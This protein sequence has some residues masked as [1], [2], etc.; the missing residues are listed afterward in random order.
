MSRSTTA[1]APRDATPILLAEEFAQINVRNLVP[2]MPKTLYETDAAGKKKPK[3]WVFMDLK[4][5]HESGEVTP[6]QVYLPRGTGFVNAT[7]KYAGGEP[8][9]ME[10]SSIKL[11]VVENPAQITETE[12]GVAAK[13]EAIQKFVVSYLD[14]HKEVAEAWGPR[15]KRAEDARRS[16]TALYYGKDESGEEAKAPL[17]DKSPS[18]EVRFRVDKRSREL[19]TDLRRVEPS[20][21]SVEMTHAELMAMTRVEV[22]SSVEIESVMFG[23]KNKSVY[24]RLVFQS[25]RVWVPLSRQER[26]NADRSY[27]AQFMDRMVK[28]YIVCAPAAAADSA[29][30]V[31]V[32]AAKRKAPETVAETEAETETETETK[33]AKGTTEAVEEEDEAEDDD[34]E[35][36]EEEEEEGDEASK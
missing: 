21:E 32:L 19:R 24:I 10:K 11:M 20:G 35:E 12:R 36:E 29:A 7:D 5:R 13:F 26:S 15:W 27:S 22:A 8:L 30:P 31:P 34:E 17:P 1:P 6:L 18:L 23:P 2:I 33:R 4:Y 28:S 25:M 3:D 14:K 9:S 16:G